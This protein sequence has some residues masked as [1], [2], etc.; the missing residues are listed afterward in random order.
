[1]AC[2]ESASSVHAAS[3]VP[4]ARLAWFCIR[5][6]PKHEHI[7]AAHLRKEHNLEVLLPRIRYK[8]VTRQGRV[9]VTEAL[10]PSYLFARFDLQASLKAVQHGR[11]VRS[12]VH[13]GDRWPTVPEAA[14]AE[15]R[16]ILGNEDVHLVAPELEPGEPVKVLGGAFRGLLAVVQQV[17]PGNDRVAVL[18]DFLGRQTTVRVDRSLLVLER[19][20]RNVAL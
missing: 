8:R 5:T 13:F 9:W 18:M 19:D 12:V 2:P 20:G 10:F 15:L 3:Q 6:Q 7:A 16:S 17:M 11:G 4:T 14:L 1:M